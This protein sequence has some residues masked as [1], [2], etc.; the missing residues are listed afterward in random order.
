MPE[1]VEMRRRRQAYIQLELLVCEKA[2]HEHACIVFVKQDLL[3]DS[4]CEGFGRL[5]YYCCRRHSNW[6]ILKMPICVAFTAHITSWIICSNVACCLRVLITTLPPTKQPIID[7]GHI[8][9]IIVLEL[10]II[11]VNIFAEC[12][13]R[14]LADVS[15]IRAVQCMHNGFMF[16]IGHKKLY[17]ARGWR[18]SALNLAK[19]KPTSRAESIPCNAYGLIKSVI[20]F[21]VTCNV[22]CTMKN[23]PVCG[24]DGLTYGNLCQMES[25]ACLW[26]L[27]YSRVLALPLANLRTSRG[28]H[29]SSHDNYDCDK[30]D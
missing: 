4:Y 6:N 20:F 9:G 28:S 12:C 5:L 26:V 25:E 2:K 17:I 7:V 1:V 8:T 30:L 19:C 11:V 16:W 10:T 3:I 23:E 18:V 15:S 27:S 29:N 13:T 14:H 22:A 21:I 24:T